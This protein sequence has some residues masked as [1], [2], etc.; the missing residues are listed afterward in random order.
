MNKSQYHLHACW[1][2]FQVATWINN[3]YLYNYLRQHRTLSCS[4]HVSRVSQVQT[5]SSGIGHGNSFPSIAIP[6]SQ[7]V[8][9]LPSICVIH[10]TVRLITRQRGY[11]SRGPNHLHHPI[12]NSTVS[13][14]LKMEYVELPAQQK[15]TDTQHLRYR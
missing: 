14:K 11:G 4:K 12:N 8:I 1:K 3:I 6:Y 15:Y 2:A 9:Y 7:T 13:S 10:E 5:N